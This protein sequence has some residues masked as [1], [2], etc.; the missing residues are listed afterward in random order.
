MTRRSPSPFARNVLEVVAP[1]L[2]VGSILDYGCGRGTDVI[3][4]RQ[5]GLHADGYDPY[6]PFGW[7]HKPTATAGYDLVTLAFVLNVLPDPWERVRVLK[8]AATYLR[9]GGH[10]LVVTR[11][12]REIQ[13]HAA[14][15]GWVPHN[16]GYSSTSSVSF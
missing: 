3:H 9:Q 14:H 2:S 4:Y 8:Q 1:K 13:T 7:A 5:G 12:P 10:M 16:D 15:A 11:S 6:P